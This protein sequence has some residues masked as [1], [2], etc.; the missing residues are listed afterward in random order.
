MTSSTLPVRTS[1]PAHRFPWAPLLV[2]SS[3]IFLSVTAEMMPTG[4]LPELGGSLGVS[5]AQAGLLVTVFAFTV[6]LSSTP[7]ALVTRR[8][9]RRTLLIAV[10]VVLTLGTVATALAPS[11]PLMVAARIV[12]GAGHG[13]FWAVVGAYSARLVRP[14]DLGRAVAVTFAGGTLAFVLGV[15]LGT[16]LGQLVGWRVSFLIVAGL[17]AAGTLLVLRVLPS[18]ETPVPD[19]TTGSI[20]T[21]R[22]GR[23]AGSVAVLC[24]AVAV[25]M[26]GH[27]A[28]TT[29]LVPFATERMGAATGAVSP[30]LFVYGA[31]GAV[32]LVIAGSRV[33]TRR[34][35]AALLVALTVVLV[36]A[37]VL[38]LVPARPLVALP[39]FVVWGVAF[40]VLPS[41]LQTRLLQVADPL[42]RDT[43]TAVYTASFNAGIGGG[44]LVGSVVYGAFGLESTAV[45]YAACFLLAIALLAGAALRARRTTAQIRTVLSQ[46]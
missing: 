20:A 17:M 26:T 7:L 45:V 21:L 16:A 2:L 43:A 28:F 8:V 22:A 10:L 39:A 11:Y 18:V 19:T 30:L 46:S 27:Y 35:V 14:R 12:G 24:V 38:N 5:P 15:P 33:V 41:L 3:V 40:G 42:I 34:P 37:V 6:V 23:G 1:A 36:S 25:A 29:Y 31:A 32:G 13:L 44:A 9:P 4:L